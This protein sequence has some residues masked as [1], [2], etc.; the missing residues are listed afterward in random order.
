MKKSLFLLSCLFCFYSTFALDNTYHYSIDLTKVSDRRLAVELIPPQLTESKI[1]FSLPKIV[2][3]TYS[4]YD[5]GRF[6]E[7][8]KA[9]DASGNPLSVTR[10]D[11]NSWEISNSTTLAKITYKVNDTYRPKIKGNPIF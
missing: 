1:V 7:D 6:V 2:P 10:I 4:I 3:G 9:Y 5:F 11:T 8:F